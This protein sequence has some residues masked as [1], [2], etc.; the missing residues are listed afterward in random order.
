MCGIIGY[1]GPRNA[2]EIVVE[3]L[4]KLEYRGYDSFG[5]A[6]RANPD[7]KILKRVG[8]IGSVTVQELGLPNSNLAIGHTRWATHGSV[9][10]INT[11][12]HISQDEK[13]IVVHNG[14]IE[15][16]QAQKKFLESQG[17]AFYSQTDT[18]IIPKTIEYHMKRGYD[19]VEACKHSLKHLEGQYAIVAL[20]K[21]ENKLVAIRKEA[22]LVIGVGE[23]EFFV[24]SDVPAFL[25][26]TKKVIFLD[27]MDLAVIDKN[28]SVFNL[29]KNSFVDRTITNIDWNAEQARKG[30]FDHFFMKEVYE[31]AN[32]LERVANIDETLIKEV[33]G[34]IRKSEGIFF[35]AC[36]TA[37]Y[38]CM[39]G[40]Y[41][42]AK[43]AKM[44]I[45][46]CL[47][48]EFPNFKHFLNNKSLVIALSQSGETADTLT[49]IR[50]AKAA[51]AKTISITNAMGSSLMRESDK[52]ILARAGPEICVLSTKA[53]TSQLAILTLLAYEL[54]GKLDEGK[55]K[56][57]EVVR[58]IYYLTSEHTRKFIQEIAKNLRYA[59]HIYLIGRGLQYPTALEATLKI[60]EVSYIHA[61]GFAGGE[62]KHGVIALIEHGTP[63]IVFTSTENEKEIISN[64]MELKARGG[65]I[66]GVGPNN[67]PVFDVWI[68]VRESEE[69]NSI[70]QIIPMQILAY[71]LAMLRGCDPDKPR[72]LAKSVTVK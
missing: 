58:Y 38:A 4:K 25:E 28:I 5:F 67:N 24:A 72:N 68:K 55:E 40:V 7:I 30:E 63:C 33:A 26:Y 56:L 70:C 54:A 11:H 64:A 60:K 15:N 20:H 53:Y 9:T 39:H 41:T 71:Q 44:H 22:P 13:I 27:E 6:V 35:V 37:S 16:F 50:A 19:F 21:D 42:F 32:T 52:T 1:I 51:G 8:K 61:E 57:K 12:P 17:L 62:L 29:T 46:F 31:Q 10:E 3:G 66:I 43:I 69:A 49:A 34:E 47:A 18:E 23:G 36:G 14:I 48:H 65:Y 45:N 59:Q 2:S